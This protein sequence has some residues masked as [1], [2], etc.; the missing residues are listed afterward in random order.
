MQALA[1]A[2]QGNQ[3]LRVLKLARVGMREAGAQALAAALCG[4]RSL[5]LLDV[6]DNGLKGEGARALRALVVPRGESIVKLCI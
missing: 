4:S 6:S 3:T 1:A 5:R 2:L